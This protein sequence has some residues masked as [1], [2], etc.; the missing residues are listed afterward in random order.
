VILNAERG[1]HTDFVTGLAWDPAE[2]IFGNSVG[3]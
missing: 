3:R 1:G 2:K